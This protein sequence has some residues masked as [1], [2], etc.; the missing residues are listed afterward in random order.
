MMTPHTTVTATFYDRGAA[1][2]P[3]SL[4]FG[5]VPIIVVTANAQSLTLQNCGDTPIAITASVR[6]RGFMPED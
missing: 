6:G 2:A 1:I 3:L 5:E 4:S